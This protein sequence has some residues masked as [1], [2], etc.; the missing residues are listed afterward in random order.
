M[1]DLCGQFID[2]CS[3]SSFETND[4]DNHVDRNWTC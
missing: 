1:S 3:C 2:L 4:A